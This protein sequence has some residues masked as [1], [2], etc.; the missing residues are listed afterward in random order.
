M[1]VVQH[2]LVLCHTFPPY[3]GI[4]GRRWAKFAKAMAS[5]GHQVHVVCSAGTSEMKGSLWTADVGAP[6][7]FV[8]ELPQRYPTV[9]FKRPLTTVADRV[10]YHFWMRAMPLLVK[11]NWFDKAILWEKQL[12]DLCGRL[13]KEHAIRNVIV[14]GAPFSLMTHAL[15]LKERHQGIHLIADFRDP[16]TWTG[17]YGYRSLSSKR[18][19]R[20]RA[21]EE[22]AVHAF[23]TII[24]PA[25]GIIDHLRTSYGGAATKYHVIPHAIDPDELAS[26]PEHPKDGTFRMVFA[27]NV[28][29][30]QVASGFFQALFDG[31]EQ[32]RTT[33]P[34]VFAKTLLDIL[35]TDGD[36]AAYR[37]EAETRGL[38]QQVRFHDPLPPREFFTLLAM[39][40]LALVFST[41][42]NK[43]FLGTKFNEL[44]HLRK[45]VLHIGEPGVVSRTIAEK[46]LGASVRLDELPTELARFITGERTIDLDPAANISDHRLDAVTD[47][48]LKLM[49]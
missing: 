39:A 48:L 3:Q 42:F 6:G 1:P 49:V 30:P 41:S 32:L 31:L 13:I 25:T 20:E 24:S 46:R 22:L 27:G 12:L 29:D 17:G 37:M 33:R 5:K 40:D 28:Y 4:G 7:I 45:P 47:A 11:G 38:G 9:L 18:Q 19:A 44:F 16:W 14:S 43:D 10:R 21:L 26:L 35:I 15:R 23:D 36:M 34:E 8:Y 2:V